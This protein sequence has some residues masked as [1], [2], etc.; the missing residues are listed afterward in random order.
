MKIVAFSVLLIVSKQMILSFFF[1]QP[2]QKEL[3]E[4][5]LIKKRSEKYRKIHRKTHVLDAVFNKIA[6]LHFNKRRLQHRCF[7]MNFCTV[8][9]NI[10]FVEQL[11]RLFLPIDASAAGNVSSFN[12][13]I[14]AAL[15]KVPEI[16]V[17]FLHKVKKLDVINLTYFLITLCVHS[18][19]LAPIYTYLQHLYVHIL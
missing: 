5:V 10:D 4:R 11:Q 18:A 6:H 19:F 12:I 14:L 9:K 1:L 17:V 8:F 7:S 15:E 13:F 3:S 2:T 16:T